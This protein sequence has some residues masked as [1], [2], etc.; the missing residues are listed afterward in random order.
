MMIL[1]MPV[2]A[3][4]WGE[5]KEERKEGWRESEASGGWG[6]HHT[7]TIISWLIFSK[8]F[9]TFRE[10]ISAFFRA[11][12]T[13]EEWSSGFNSYI[14]W[15]TVGRA[16]ASLAAATVSAVAV[17]PRSTRVFCLVSV[18]CWLN[19]SLKSNCLPIPE[20]GSCVGSSC[21]M[22]TVDGKEVEKR[23]YTPYFMLV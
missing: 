1:E 21:L 11:S 16:G 8:H 3:G 5:E 9:W 6:R 23:Q 14:H 17:K 13:E 10:F 12:V 4:L 7:G 15:L 2:D 19:V 18:S 22:T 20:S